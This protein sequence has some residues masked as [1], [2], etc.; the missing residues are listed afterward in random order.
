M[1]MRE[2]IKRQVDRAVEPL[3]GLADWHRIAIGLVGI[4][5]LLMTFGIGLVL[6]GDGAAELLANIVI[7]VGGPLA[8][9]LFVVTLSILLF[10]SLLGAGL[11]AYLDIR[12]LEEEHEGELSR[13]YIAGIVAGPKL[14]PFNVYCLYKIHSSRRLAKT[15]GEITD[16]SLIT[17][18]GVRD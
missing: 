17:Q 15:T 3:I 10:G 16:V 5:T 1:T 14:F 8:G 13:L 11:A 9:W 4:Q 18:L 6:Y 12:Q 2:S 7:G